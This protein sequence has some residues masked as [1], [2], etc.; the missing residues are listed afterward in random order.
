MRCPT[1]EEPTVSAGTLDLQRVEYR[2]DD[3]V[4]DTEYEAVFTDTTTQKEQD[5]AQYWVTVAE[6][7]KKR[8]FNAGRHQKQ[9]QE[10]DA[11]NDEDTSLPRRTSMPSWPTACR[12][13]HLRRVPRSRTTASQ[14]LKRPQIHQS[15][16]HRGRPAHS[17]T[18]MIQWDTT[19]GPSPRSRY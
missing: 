10:A 16:C 5:A 11:H 4:L 1:A 18:L 19:R 13:S 3:D 8:T 7:N 14:R 2:P 17:A 9:Q 12:A 15:D 6:A